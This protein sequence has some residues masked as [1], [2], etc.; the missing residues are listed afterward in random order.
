MGCL[1]QLKFLPSG[2]Q[3][4]GRQTGE[5]VLVMGKSQRD[6]PALEARL[7]RVLCNSEQSRSVR[8]GTSPAG[9]Q[10]PALSEG[11]STDLA[12]LSDSRRSLSNLC[13]LDHASYPLTAGLGRASP[14]PLASC[15]CS[16]MTCLWLSCLSVLTGGNPPKKTTA[17]TLKQQ[18][19]VGDG[20]QAA[21]KEK[22]GK[23]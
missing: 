9:Q 23:K 4:L 12:G 8:D 6:C 1:R 22:K 17:T 11:T 5:S 13:S 10:S 21:Q 7:G 19:G 18:M 20:C 3:E 14:C 15:S 2:T 16:K